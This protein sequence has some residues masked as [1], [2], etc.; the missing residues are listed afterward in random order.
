MVTVLNWDAFQEHSA[1]FIYELHL[2]ILMPVEYI[3][4]C[5][6]YTVYYA[7]LYLAM[8]HPIADILCSHQHQSSVNPRDL[9]I[10]LNTALNT[11][12]VDWLNMGVVFNA[13]TTVFSKEQFTP[14]KYIDILINC[15]LFTF[16]VG[17]PRCRW[18]F[19]LHQNIKD[20]FQLKL[21]SFWF[22]K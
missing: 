6:I 10:T 13:N 14:N 17:H 3:I 5:I 8:C 9:L 2:I 7:W 22:V 1:C 12:F 21:W 4:V 18:L 15:C 19:F 20:D 11:A 16:S